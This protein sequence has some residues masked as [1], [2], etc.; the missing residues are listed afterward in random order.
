MIEIPNLEQPTYAQNELAQLQQQYNQ[1][2]HLSDDAILSETPV[3][4]GTLPGN[5]KLPSSSSIA[6]QLG[7]STR[8]ILL[9][10]PI[11]FDALSPSQTSLPQLINNVQSPMVADL[12]FSSKKNRENFEDAIRTPELLLP[13]A[14]DDVEE[15][16][17]P[18]DYRPGSGSLGS[19]E[20]HQ[21]EIYENTSAFKISPNPPDHDSSKISLQLSEFATDLDIEPQEV[22]YNVATLYPMILGRSLSQPVTVSVTQEPESASVERFEFNENKASSHLETPNLYS[23]L[24]FAT[25]Q[26][27]GANYIESAAYSADRIEPLPQ[28]PPSNSEETAK[29]SIADGDEFSRMRRAMATELKNP[30]EYTL[31]ILFTQFVRHAERKLNLCLD[32]PLSQEPPIIELLAEGTDP[33]FDTIVASL[34]YIAKRKP[35][36]VMDSVMFWR[37]SKSEVA[38]MASTELERVSSLGRS[39]SNAR[40]DSLPTSLTL[41][42]KSLIQKPLLKGKRSL[43]LMRTRSISKLTQKR[44]VST[45]AV[46]Q[47]AN[48][49]RSSMETLNDSNLENLRQKQFYDEQVLSARET[50]IQ[51]ER[52]SLASIYILCRVLIEVV[53]QTT[54][55][56][57]GAD[58]SRKLEDIVYNQLK[59]TDP[60]ATSE[61]FVRLAN[62]NLFSKLLGFMSEKSFLSVSDR[63]IADLEKV[64]VLVRHDDEP[65]THLLIHGMRYLKL[66]NYPLEKFEESAEFIQSVTKFFCNTQNHTIMLA[67]ADVLSDL[68]LPLASELTAEA[69]HPLWVEAVSSIYGKAYQMWQSLNSNSQTNTS[70]IASAPNAGK[71]FS[72]DWES[73]LTLM[74]SALS[75]SSK[76][77]FSL[78][79]FQII[80]ANAHRLKAKTDAHVKTKLMISL[81]RLLWVYINRLPDTLNNTV[82]KLDRIFDILFFGPN[83]SGKKQN[84]VTLDMALIDSIAQVIRIVAFQHFNYVL[85]NVILKLLR[86]SFN[87]S[88]MEIFAPE[89]LIFVLKAY[90]LCLRD[91]KL[92]ERPVFPSDDQFELCAQSIPGFDSPH[93]LKDLFHN[94]QNGRFRKWNKVMSEQKINKHYESHEEI[95]KSFSL[96]MKHLDTQCGMSN[97]SKHDVGLSSNFKSLSSLTH[98]NFGLEFY[99]NTKDVNLGLFATL[100][101]A[102]A[103]TIAPLSNEKAQLGLSL[104]GII[105]MLIRNA[106]HENPYV[107]SAAVN[108][109]VK[110]ASRK[111]AGA[112][113]T[114]YARITFK[115]SEKTGLPYD[116]DYFS[117]ESFNRLLRI[118]VELLKCWLDQ[119]SDTNLASDT[120]ESATDND[121]MNNG[122]LNDLYQINF[123]APDLTNLEP[124]S[125]KLKPYEELEWKGIMTVIEEV[126]GN[127]LFFL[128]SDDSKIRLSA[129][130]ILKIVEQFDQSI[131]NNTDK[132]ETSLESSSS[133]QKGHSRTSSKY[134]ADEGTRVIQVIE[135]IDFFELIRP[136]K[137]ELSMPERSRLSNIKNKKG[138]ILKFASSDYGI[139]S[140]IWFRMF[141]RLLDILFERCPMPVAMCRSIVCVRLVQ[142]H[143]Y[144]VAF[145]DH[146][147]NYT[148]SLFGKTTPNT[149][150]QVLVNQ[151][152]LY[153]IFACCSLTSTNEQKIS[154]PTQPMHGRKKSLPMYIQHQKIT[155]AKSVFRMVI[156]LLKSSQSMIREA[157][158]AGLSCI[159]INTCKTFTENLPQS[160]TDWD[161]HS[162]K[163][164]LAEDKLRIEIIHVFSIISNRFKSG[165]ALYSDDLIVANLVSIIKNVKVFLS[166]PSV[167]TLPEFQRLRFYFTSFLEN[168]FIGLKDRKDLN[169]WLPF[170]ARI[171]CFNFLKEWCGF[172]DSK[173]VLEERYAIMIQKANQHKDQAATVAILELEK[174]TFQIASLSCMA[175]LCSGV[176]NQSISVPG[177]IAVMSFDIKSVMNWVHEIVSSDNAKVQEQGKTALKNI[178]ASNINNPEIYSEAL[179]QCYS[180]DNS[181]NVKEIYFTHVVNA[182]IKFRDVETMPYEIFCISTFLIGSDSYET[183]YAAILCIKQIEKKF[184]KVSFIDEFYESACCSTMVVYKKVLFDYSMKLASTHTSGAFTYISYLTKYFNVVDHSTR[185]DILTCLLPWVQTVELKYSEPEPSAEVVKDAV[186]EIDE[187]MVSESGKEFDGASLMILNNL[188]EITVKFSKTISNEVEALWVALGTNKPNFDL[189]CDYIVRNCLIRRN[190]VFVSHS[191]QIISYLVFSKPDYYYIIDKL[192]AN[193][194]PKAMV[195]LQLHVTL[196]IKDTS[197][198][199]YTANLDKTL[200]YNGKK[201][202][203]SL[204]QLSM[205]FLVDLFRSK[206][207]MIIQHLPLLLH[208]S[209]SL[210]D[211]YYPLVQ[212]Q[213]VALLI[214]LIHSIAPNDPKS[215][216]I[217]SCL[218]RK[219]FQLYIWMYDDL[220]NEKGSGITP[221]NMDLM[222]R[223]V[224][225]LFSP[226]APKLQK[227][228]SRISLKWATIC[229]VRHI[230]CRSFQIF[231]SLLS[232]MDQ[233]MLKDMLH[234][235]SNTIADDSNDIQG[236]AMQILMTTNAITAELDSDKLINFPQLFWS[237]I[238]CLS[239]IHEHE[240]I[241]T[242]SMMSKFV[243]KIDLDAPDTISCLVSTFPPKWEGKF[244]GLQEIV[245]VGLKSATAYD[246]TLKF[247]DKLNKLKD[248]DII[249]MGDQRLVTILIA[250]F[251]RFLHTLDEK[252]IKPD[253][254]QA[255]NHI[256]EM[257]S[258][259]GRVGLARILNSL[260]KNKF[261]SKKEFL[262][263]TVTCIKTSFFPTYQAQA[264]LLLLGFLSNKLQWVKLET[265]SILKHLLP[266]VDLSRDEFVGV[267]AD[268]ISPLLRLLLTKYAEQAL[269]V[270]DEAKFIPGS[271]LDKDILRM[272][273][274]NA[275]M[276]KDYEQTYTLF[277]IPDES[278][279]AI[280]MPVITAARTRHNVHAVFITCEETSAVVDKRND[281]NDEQVHFLMEDYYAPHVDHGDNASVGVEDPAASLSNMWAALDDFDSFFTKPSDQR[282]LI[283]P[284]MPRDFRNSRHNHSVSVDTKGSNSSDLAS[285]IDTVPQVYEKKALLILNRSL[286]RTQSN[287][288]FKSSLA[289]NFGSPSNPDHQEVVSTRRSYLPFRNSRLGKHK[290]EALTPIMA[291]GN[292]ESSASS[293]PMKGP[294]SY[295]AASKTSGS[296]PN[297]RTLSPQDPP[298]TPESLAPESGT[299]LDHILGG[300]RKKNR[301]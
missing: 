124:S 88:T 269:E 60:V 148:T 246:V 224:L 163:R 177:K 13:T 165:S 281:S 166:V 11:Q 175:T 56:A 164:D 231:R 193:L 249:G 81:S 182:F 135:N 253:V 296:T 15:H 37:K 57:L 230:A 260:A 129:I 239:T 176:L 6:H 218:R 32:Y 294:Y 40:L 141:P 87:M 130:A 196:P 208:V 270:I 8:N 251:P 271:Q 108:S 242:I 159:N 41:T 201:A 292:F 267:G 140:T 212:E 64:P 202:A 7:S 27:Y 244:E 34:G 274:G 275:S 237:S 86:S 22:A 110:L 219:D 298:L 211:H 190:L 204:G 264:L 178:V 265:L 285:P 235:L 18:A 5:E 71:G 96:L 214:H 118:Y 197:M 256:S 187:F 213:A 123:K 29:V 102:C 61:S 33:Q 116:S 194:R 203:F 139:D 149:P 48:T 290:S 84:W 221:K 283:L 68:I 115:I 82:K 19:N 111:N 117:S 229:A 121:M 150:P 195:P 191:R 3:A 59:T 250:N 153:L 288:S 222:V 223:N 25:P 259:C 127:G 75:V 245:M 132:K 125:S 206:N 28:L 79:W 76:E 262:V 258:A 156:P 114:A 53:K 44:N 241:E 93:A 9:E 179:K 174:K 36:P 65:K 122:A 286:A 200:E 210:M 180:S 12:Y 287:T 261:R 20:L 99:N 126:E 69:N 228:W 50:A 49:T 97:W 78:S 38:S 255:C 282:T 183:R 10:L 225:E 136:F 2:D 63:F 89:K 43:S 112:L 47:T 243:S 161:I 95:C 232:F 31:H 236:F 45:S 4:I 104:Q 216:N 51:A 284:Q 171:G 227:D 220:N 158:I 300:G 74:V 143:E 39:N 248:S 55:D 162:K 279:W 54:L 277:G 26:S 90:V 217:I 181:L 272:S 113:L 100:L 199:P 98:F 280:P 91:Y 189:M 167:Q 103:W 16:L 134:V 266:L 14:V 66:T 138:L 247:L 131:Y 62:W 52:K 137:K 133:S 30:A 151:W 273:M 42:Y 24:S 238:A 23:S 233:S 83:V 109:L 94:T 268:L 291:P 157:V 67:Y 160:L 128:T 168:V 276:R 234:R 169:R 299:R 155:S 293:T 252:S 119:F 120:L 254:E 21:K 172:G 35:K 205:V 101:D 46:P 146:F 72:S 80:E 184:L 147:K 192:I 215:I 240:F 144:V 77:V 58:L 152:K 106:I 170:E 188:F 107:A 185:R 17:V 198:Y 207:D 295:K 154:I 257:A 263:Q 186:E 289:D 92:G 85:E 226:A 142:M 105:D 301:R 173:S 278:G 1:T 70:N 73:S 209:F 297:G 145:S